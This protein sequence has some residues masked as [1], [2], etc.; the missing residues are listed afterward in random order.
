MPEHDEK[1]SERIPGPRVPDPVPVRLAAAETALVVMDITDPICLRRPTCVA[2]VPRIASL[3]AA[4]RAAGVRVVHT[5]G[6]RQPTTI[7]DAAAPLPG[8]PVVAGRADKFFGT[9]LDALLGKPAPRTLVLAGTAANGAV[10]YTSFAANL[11]GYTVVVPVDAVSA[12]DD[13]TQRFALWQLLNQPG[14]VNPANE[15][16]APGRVTLSSTELITFE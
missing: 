2:S 13:A 3:L 6:P 10:L 4:A 15:A 7:L 9:D 11:R 5:V 16:G 8:E 12:D 14:M 1:A